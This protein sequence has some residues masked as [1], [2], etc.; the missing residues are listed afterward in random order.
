MNFRSISESNYPSVS[1]EIDPT[2]SEYSLEEYNPFPNDKKEKNVVCPMG[3]TL[4]WPP[5][6]PL[7]ECLYLI[8]EPV[9]YFL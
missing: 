9:G 7:H 4:Y 8:V 2:E 6:S 3:W 1:M 5:H